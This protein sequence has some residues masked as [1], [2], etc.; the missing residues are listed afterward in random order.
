MSTARESLLTPHSHLQSLKG[1][2]ARLSVVETRSSRPAYIT[3][4]PLPSVVFPSATPAESAARDELITMALAHLFVAE[5][6]KLGAFAALVP[7]V[8]ESHLKLGTAARDKLNSLLLEKVCRSHTSIL[9]P[10]VAYR[11]L[12]PLLPRPRPAAFEDARPPLLLTRHGLVGSSG[13]R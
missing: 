4:A 2:G 13:L 5:P 12:V 3:D 1:P 10:S 11:F 6:A 7:E 9:H 8:F